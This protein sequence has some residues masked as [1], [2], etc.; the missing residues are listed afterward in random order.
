MPKRKQ[1]KSY[2]DLLKFDASQANSFLARY[3]INFRFVT[4]FILVIIL[5]GVWGLMTLPRR[6]NPEIKIPIVFIATVLP[7]AS[8]ED[9][10]SLFTIPLEDAVQSVD[11]IQEINSTSQ[12]NISTIVIEFESG[13][14][15]EQARSD[16]Q[17][18][19]DSVAGELPEDAADPNVAALDFEDIP[20][21]TFVVTG[22]SDL[23]SLT[24]FADVVEK[25]IEA[26]P[27][28][29]NVIVTGLEQEEIQVLVKPEI[30]AEYGI[31]PI[32]L[33]QTIKSQTSSY[34]AGTVRSN[35]FAYP[36]SIDPLISSLDDIRLTSI[37]L[38]GQTV[39][40]S[41]IA[42]ISLH[43]SPNQPKSFYTDIP[44]E[45]ERS[46]TFSVFKQQG[47][48]I[49]D[50]SEEIKEEMDLI[51]KEFNNRFQVISI[52]DM[53]EEIENQFTELISNLLQ[54]IFLV[55]LTLFLFLGFKQASI[56][57]LIIPLSFFITFAAMQVMGIT[58]NFLSLFALILS[59]GSFVDTA[60]VIISA[61]TTYYATK[62][63]TPQ[64]TGLLVWKDFFSALVA[65]T[66]TN[67]WGF[68][69]LLLAGGII[70]EFIRTIPI[71]VT[72][73]LIASIIV[74]FLVTLPLMVFVLKPSI[75][76]RVIYLLVGVLGGSLVLLAG[77]YLR[78]SYLLI[79]AI[80]VVVMVM[81]A[82]AYL[83]SPLVE[84]C[85]DYL[86][87]KGYY[88]PLSRFFTRVFQEGYFNTRGFA[89]RYE[90]VLRR[91]LASQSWRRKVMA[92]VI[93]VFLFS[94]I[95]VPLGYV[96]NVFFPKTDEDVV[97]VGV[98]FS[99][100]ATYE[101]TTSEALSIL[102]VLSKIEDVD[103]IT[104]EIGRQPMTESTQTEAESNQVVFSLLL[105]EDRKRTSYNIA[106]SLRN[107][108][109]DYG[110]GDVSVVELMGG[111]PVGADIV[112]TISGEDL[113]VLQSYADRVVDYLENYEGVVDVE[114][115][116]VPGVG[117]LSF[118]PD[119]QELLEVNLTI[120][121]VGLWLRTYVSGFTLEEAEITKRE[122]QQ[123]V[124]RF[125]ESTISPEE[126]SQLS[127]PVPGGAPVPLLSLGKIQLTTNPTL[128]TRTD[129]ERTISVS[130]T[131][132]PGFNP[133]EINRQLGKFAD[134]EL[135]LSR[136]YSWSTGGQ[137]EENTQAV[138]SIIMAMLLAFVLILGTMV[139]QFRSYRQAVIVILVIP[140]ALSG[141]F[142]IFALT[143]TPLSFPALIG[144]LALF[145]IVVNNSIMMV[146]KINQNLEQRMGFVDAISEGTASRLE[147]ILFTSVTAII[148]LIPITLSDPLWQG[149]GGAII[150]GLTFSGTIALL[151]IPVVYYMWFVGEKS[152]KV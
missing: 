67:I 59:I 45:T 122:N 81:F 34:P 76:R 13:I 73:T 33:S 147:P 138:Q 44:G 145:G 98:D 132:E 51:T 80:I 104:T 116:I 125:T 1:Y 89:K 55:F 71:V 49:D 129:D 75:P 16:V 74:T 102:S 82:T 15:P 5:L 56:T 134:T 4:L 106:Q 48:N 25:R 86:K 41:E 43:S 110:K 58:I 32:Q 133:V 96:K 144:V 29:N 117:K 57:L 3:L 40:L 87:Q 47:A 100:G 19:I 36:V 101:H 99:P 85:A 139:I 112:V 54:T 88:A 21:W 70:G 72:T 140:L 124:F 142:I 35:G 46:I 128:I 146:E 28:V 93:I 10:E 22:T 9:V 78:D 77:M 24:R 121:Q 130:G 97:Y 39:R 27:I 50:A 143:G 105:T 23:A 38:N 123:I 137:N 8:P 61:M 68:V 148:G 119:R 131:A 20:V 84:K 11:N 30:L 90:G 135:D 151:F 66:I 111:P 109:K 17:S 14:E 26:L 103:F 12:E 2:F 149:L 127:I 18:A 115:S 53:G 114:K 92:I 69:P 150:A 94:I 7:G 141:V 65:S 120:D 83:K 152:S 107:Q 136:G 6:L 91:I 31:S 63:F 64:Q 79:P 42:D 126:L 95:L 108:F 118:I 52:M 62:K 37:K 113:A 60:I